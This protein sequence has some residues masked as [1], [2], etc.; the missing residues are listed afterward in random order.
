MDQH[1]KVDIQK[2]SKLLEYTND[3]TIRKARSGRTTIGADR[4][5]R[6]SQIESP[7][8]RKP[9]LD[10]LLTGRGHPLLPR[11]DSKRLRG[12][13]SRLINFIE[14]LESRKI[15]ALEMVLGLTEQT[16]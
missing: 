1:L 16:K 5:L 12:E 10:W 2:L 15:R 9:N 14:R 3:T 13:L 11:D 8:G 6:L 4:L 7:D